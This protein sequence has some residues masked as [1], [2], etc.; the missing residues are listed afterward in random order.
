M[1]IYTL[2]FKIV[3]PRTI[4]KIIIKIVKLNLNQL[5]QLI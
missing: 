1:Y 4:S 2:V 5:K 3:Q